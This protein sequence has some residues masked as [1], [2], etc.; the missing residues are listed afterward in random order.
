MKK[1]LAWFRKDEEVLKQKICALENELKAIGRSQA[2]IEFTLD[3]IILDANEN[4]LSA[5]GYSREE[6]VGKHH[7]MFAEPAYAKSAAYAEFWEKLGGGNFD[8]AEYKRIAKGGR[9]VWIQASYNPILGADGKPF[10]VVKYA[11]DVTE[12]KLVNADFAG[13]IDAVSKSQ[14]TIEFN[15]DGTII[16]ANENFLKTTGY[17][18]QEVA[19]KHHSMFALPEYAKSAEYKQF[20][21]KLNRGEFDAGEYKRFG[22]GGRE[23][24][25]QASYNPIY[26]L[27]GKPFKVVK[28]ATDVTAQKVM[29]EAVKEV[30]DDTKR[31]MSF[32]AEGNL[33][34]S[35][36]NTHTGEFVELSEFVNACID[37]LKEVVISIQD[38]SSS[39]SS[40]ADQIASGTHALSQRTEEQASSLE[41]TA[42][43]MEQMTSSVKQ[44]ADNA[45]EANNLADG[46]R[47]LAEKGGSVVGRA[48]VAMNEINQASRKIEN[49]TGVI[50]EIAF[51]TNL[52][53]L[54]AAVE[55]ARAGEQGRGFAVVA[56]EVRNLAQRSA[57]A[58]KE[59]KDLIENSVEKVDDGTKLVAESGSTL[60]E[61][62][63]SSTKVSQIIAEIASASKEQS[64]GL[65]Q[66][67]TAVMGLDEMTQQN[68]ALVEEAAASSSIMGER[69]SAMTELVN[70]FQIDTDNVQSINQSG[71][72]LELVRSAGEGF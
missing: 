11:T 18:L 68:A 23:V 43:A 17:S 72:S 59:I 29:A 37:K 50:D 3:G 2:V 8:A 52:L 22:K 61:I 26:D 40:E 46:A 13:Q 14:A 62:V 32:V 70:Y 49:I 58:A 60:E 30:L 44:N 48:V 53:A 7:R 15:M 57:T 45:I 42:S 12:Q 51:Q 56:S 24:W 10:K 47:E 66:V 63:S 19:G 65:D 34:H 54:N 39:V 5:M 27:N 20:W 9:E 38:A 16:T 35:M 31:V 67:N 41:E 21:E 4:F 71:G 69:A 64:V 55:A 33:R 25:I 6:V 36:R 28:Y 1:I